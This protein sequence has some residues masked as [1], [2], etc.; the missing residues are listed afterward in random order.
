MIMKNKLGM[1][2]MFAAMAM[3]GTETPHREREYIKP[4]QT[5]EERKRRIA[6]AEI[7]RAKANGLKEFFYGENSLYALNQKNADR[8]AR[9]KNWL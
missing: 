9:S 8:K 3:M 7:E 5:D 4:K 6:K 2:G 1:M